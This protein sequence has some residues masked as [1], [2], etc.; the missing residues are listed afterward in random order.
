V[1]TGQGKFARKCVQYLIIKAN[2]PEDEWFGQ[3]I[4]ERTM[5]KYMDRGSLIVA[6][7]TLVLFI[8]ALFTKGISHD[9]FLETGVFLVSVK[10]II[11]AYKSSVDVN[12]MDNKI[13]A[14]LAILSKTNVNKENTTGLSQDHHI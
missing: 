4:W 9:L 12:H 6:V 5:N 1:I 13:D 7:I 11:M 14:I 10:I 8:A 3:S 2:L